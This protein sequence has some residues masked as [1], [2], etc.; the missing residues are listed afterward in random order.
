MS[1]DCPRA[2][3]DVRR[4]NFNAKIH[5]ECSCDEKIKII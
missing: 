4:D 3:L 2:K 1:I 5:C